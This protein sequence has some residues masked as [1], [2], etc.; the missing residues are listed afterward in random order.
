MTERELLVGRR[1]WRDQLGK[2]DQPQLTD[3][4][5]GKLDPDRLQGVLLAEA[6]GHEG[7]SPYQANATGHGQLLYRAGIP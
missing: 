7:L 6:V 3:Q 2:L 4:L 1:P 5:D